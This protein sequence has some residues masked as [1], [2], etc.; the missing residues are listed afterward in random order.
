M[1]EAVPAFLFTFLSDDGSDD[2]CEAGV[3]NGREVGFDGL[4]GAEDEVG[5]GGSEDDGV[6]EGGD[7]EGVFAGLDGF[8]AEFGE[9]GVCGEGVELLLL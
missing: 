5:E 6:L 2:L 3:A 8:V 7:R 4:E 9:D 1:Q